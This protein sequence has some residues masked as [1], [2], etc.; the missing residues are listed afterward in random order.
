M[1]YLDEMTKGERNQLGTPLTHPMSCGVN[2]VIVVINI[3]EDRISLRALVP[4][5]DP[6]VTPV[7]LIP[8]RNN[9]VTELGAFQLTH[10]REMNG[11][12]T[13]RHGSEGHGGPRRLIP[14]WNGDLHTARTP[15][16]VLGSPQQET[17]CQGVHG[18]A[19]FSPQRG[20][21]AIES[22]GSWVG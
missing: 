19:D 16:R 5:D 18:N 12:V 15:N 17:E 2:G 4:N 22:S 10:R 1:K 14:I 21:A 6:L 9:A 13:N 3:D 11:S 8:F 20:G 7:G